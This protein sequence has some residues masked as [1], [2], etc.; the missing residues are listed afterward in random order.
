MKPNNVIMNVKE[1][2]DITNIVD[3][4]RYR[5]HNQTD[6][7]AYIYLEDG[8]TN[9]EKLTY[10]ELEI[11][12]QA[13][14]A[15][16][17]SKITSGD[18]ALLLYPPGLEYISAFLGC[19]YAG[20][21]AVPVYPP[22]PTQLERSLA[23][24][25]SIIK[26]AEPSVVLTTTP[27]LKLSDEL[28]ENDQDFKRMEWLTTDDI[29]LEL[30][31]VWETP[32]IDGNTL[33]FLQYTSG[34]TGMP[35]GV[36]ISHG[37]LIHNQ[38]II[39]RISEH[40][41]ELVGFSWL[42]LYHDMGLI[43][44]VLHTLYMGGKCFLM[45]PIAFLQK[46]I[47][48]VSAISRYKAN[49]SVAPNFAYELLIKAEERENQSNLDLSTW[50]ITLNGAEPIRPQTIE[51]FM[52]AFERYGFRRQTFSPC[53]GMAEATLMITGIEK[54]V[55]PIIL[56]VNKSAIVKNQVVVSEMNN[57]DSVDFV[58]CGRI[59]LGQRISIVDPGSSKELSSNN[60]GEIWVSGQS[61]AQGYWNN[62]EDTRN[63]FSAYLTDTGEGPFLRT[64]DLGFVKDDHLFVTGRLK[65][66]IITR[67]QNHYPQDIELT[68]EMS[69]KAIR[70]GCIAAFSIEVEDEEQLV[71]VAEL[72]IKNGMPDT[73]SI[74][75]EIRAAV[76]EHHGIY[77]YAVELLPPKGIHKTSSGKIQRYL[78]RKSFIEGTLDS[79]TRCYTNKDV[80][81]GLIPTSE[82]NAM[83]I[84]SVDSKIS[85]R[86][87]L[88]KIWS[89]ILDVKYIDIEDNF[90]HLGGSSIH[91]IQLLCNINDDFNLDLPFSSIYKYPMLSELSEYI[92]DNVHN[93]Q[94]ERNIHSIC[95]NPSPDKRYYPF[96]LTDIQ[97]AYYIGR[98]SDFELG[99]VAAHSY[100]E[101]D[102][103][104][105]KID[106]TRLNQAFQKII[107]RHDM[108]RVVMLPDGQQKVLEYVEPYSISV[109]DL[110]RHEHNAVQTI[111]SRIRNEMSHQVIDVCKWP[112]FEIKATKI[113]STQIR[114]HISLDLLLADAMSIFL[115]IKELLQFYNNPYL[116][117][118]DLQVTFKDYI[119]AENTFRNTAK[120]QRSKDY[121]FKRLETLPPAPELPLSSNPDVLER[122]KFSRRSSHLNQKQ[123]QE[124][125][126][127]SANAGLSPSGLL[128]AAFSEILTLWSKSPNFTI[129]LTYFNRLPLHQQVNS[130]VGDFTSLILLE[131][132]NSDKGS[133]I[134]RATNIQKQLW[135]DLDH[136]A[137]NGVL[138]LRELARKQDNLNKAIMPV[139]FTSMLGLNS[140]GPEISDLQKL[141]DKVYAISQTPQV[142]LD[143]QVFEFNEELFF[144]WDTVD[145]LFPEGLL[146]DMFDAYCNLLNLL[147][148][149]EATIKEPCLTEMLLKPQLTHRK[150]LN[151]TVAPIS[152]EFL[153][154]LFM[155]QASREPENLAVISNNRVITYSELLKLSLK[156]GSWLQKN[157]IQPN[158]LVGVVMDK[159]WEQVVAVLGILFAGGAYLPID[160]H[161]PLDRQSH[162]LAD[163]NVS[164]V[165][166]QSKF[167]DVVIQDGLKYLCID[168]ESLENEEPRVSEPSLSIDDLAYVIYT[169]GSTGSPKGV[170]IDH[171]GAVN[172]IL[173]I[174]NRFS[175]TSKDRVLGLSSLNFD[176]SVYDVFGILAAGG[177]IVI[178][179]DDKL[180][181]PAHWLH[182]IKQYNISI[183][184]TVPAL[185]R[186]MVDYHSE[187][188]DDNHR[189]LR[190]IM[191][192]GDWI[193]LDLPKSIRMLW[194]SSEIISLGGATEASIWS[195]YFSIKNV[196]TNWKSIPYG[197]PLVNQTF[198][199]LDS[200]LEPRPVWVPGEL[201]IGGIGLAAGY[202]NNED[203]TNDQF[204][205][206]PRT[207]ERLYK[208]GDLGRYMSDGNI[209]FLGREDFQVKINGHRIELGEIEAS[210]LDH[211]NVKEAIVSAI[212]PARYLQSL[213]AYI[214]P[215]SSGSVDNEA[216][217]PAEL[218]GVILDPIERMEFKLKQPGIRI[219][220]QDRT[221]IPFKKPILD[222]KLKRKYL[223]RQSYRNF[224]DATIPFESFGL[225]LSCLQQMQLDNI[226]LPKYRYPSA[227]N[228]YPVQCYL[229]VK[230]NRIENLQSGIYYYHPVKH[231]LALIN[232]SSDFDANIFDGN[233]S[234]FNESAFA[235]FLLGQQ[236]AIEPMYGNWSKD[237]SV[238][239]AGYIGQLLMEEAPKHDIGLC[240]IGHLNFD[241]IA[242]LFK[243]DESHDLLH[244]FL[245]GKIDKLQKESWMDSSPP[246]SSLKIEDQL[247]I[248]LSNK[249]PHYMIPNSFVTLSRMP[250]SSNGKIDRNALPR[251]EPK[252]SQSHHHNL[253]APQSETEE[254]VLK[255]WQDLLEV[256]EISVHDNFFEIG[257]DSLS[258]VQLRTLMKSSFGL[259]LPMK[260]LFSNATISQ[261]SNI[262]DSTQK[263]D[264]IAPD[265]ST[266]DLENEAVLDSTIRCQ[267][268][269]TTAYSN[270]PSNI[271]ITG[272]TG[273]LGAFLLNDLLE[274]TEAEITC[275]VRGKNISAGK[276][277]I[278]QNLL[279]YGMSA[280]TQSSRIKA[281]IGDLSQPKLGLTDFDFEQLSDEIDT[282]YHNGASVNFIYTFYQL[283]NVNVLGTHEI[284]RLAALNKV[285]PLH[286]V[287]STRVFDSEHKSKLNVISEDGWLD[288]PL[289]TEIGYNQSKW[290]AE[291]LVQIARNRGLPISI[292]RP[293]QITGHSIN[294][295]SNTKDLFAR[296]IK[297]CIQLGCAPEI[298]NT[299]EMVPVDYVSSAIIN[300]SME[301]PMASKNYH[302]I[303][304]NRIPY[305][306]I[307]DWIRYRGYQLR[308]VPYNKWL[309]ELR[310]ELNISSANDLRSLFY[311]FSERSD[312]IQREAPNFYSSNTKADLR[313]NNINCP[314]SDFGLFNRYMEF[315]EYSGFINNE[316]Y[317]KYSV[318][319]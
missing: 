12:A 130:I 72:K 45:S 271:L 231:S 18:R 255:I 206:H 236:S 263:S 151:K 102:F 24:L 312:N 176:L 259:E 309:S 215:S 290:V 69:H 70:A 149:N 55:S 224:L 276:A 279:N 79:I 240:P 48:W 269:K 170:M 291:R 289:V 171:R 140:F 227:G 105:T 30:A 256:Q 37:N 251:P 2:S 211:P 40:T 196:N 146:D 50:E 228:L 235:I 56:N 167:K 310:E 98:D 19:L 64:G 118:P 119:Y 303:N 44:S 250:L 264:K 300:L 154:S 111:L 115:L 180:K 141:G 60:I 92:N 36:M 239:E 270:K 202:W 268:G 187:F 200:K 296:F 195:I 106:F 194:P 168:D 112:L 288:A 65:D 222:E 121:W 265:I 302:L 100:F 178:P 93:N 260:L 219:V 179:D 281:V 253:V 252:N 209:E 292:Y 234:I 278:V 177:A 186:M 317:K 314:T 237:F 129:N 160:A 61:V 145:D 77:P 257:G 84:A 254:L 258:A 216:Y 41:T 157:A 49:A 249:L 54:N 238:L 85:V 193:P 32:E 229:Y 101:F 13:I 17:Q 232:R 218:E 91:A 137:F 26:N 29:D 159:G 272:A 298:D 174:N 68:V 152:S 110:S 161:L 11:L 107:Q 198:H 103:K 169:S 57:E 165:L 38:T 293:G 51:R 59:D 33:A 23:R 282:I 280:N 133:F 143:H 163:G 42:P 28:L 99:N 3:L 128:I 242:D 246:L 197:K 172:T 71:I 313:G 155:R 1:L 31:S 21:I 275:L 221:E 58:S 230:S 233:L 213:I 185:M 183:W 306:D 97:Q 262:V 304:E 182:L 267:S 308:L 83:K 53:Y 299:I 80:D 22:D 134:S 212:G 138:I 204:I 287:S 10:N 319:G 81:T 89:D 274:S 316:L 90:F 132:N 261:I 136:S 117:L 35:K 14:A 225:L 25:R 15:K 131:I 315:F 156:T 144:N 184:N 66:M 104:S 78:C 4:L 116:S 5:A 123:W 162:L 307:I 207:N 284:I 191:M 164:L 201:Y 147:S 109:E 114:L 285:K 277:K 6:K 190:L 220:E 95:I 94:T 122:P 142:L 125:K 43:G 158:T 47:R 39:Q 8:E 273:F 301:H 223:E 52:N 318:S 311:L 248:H 199:V 88:I 203:K 245:C 82:D 297:G 139:V 181:D 96:P 87:K 7:T 148:V 189:N 126:T 217:E 16:L 63:T 75:E 247:K 192:S 108:L 73:K 241:S 150:L 127:L 113:N 9:E 208:T 294:G 20:I 286:Y 153:H 120:Y 46:P 295:I 305:S 188:T 135:S 62:V 244:T 124:L 67:G 283:K 175:V 214:V 243:L 266:V 166:T 27:I 210:M 76:G 226:P 34:S 205:I 173:D 74:I 86:R